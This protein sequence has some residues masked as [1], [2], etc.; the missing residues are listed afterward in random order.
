MH[1]VDGSSQQP[2]YEFDAVRLELE[3]FSPSLSEK[4]YIVAFNK[5]DLPDACEKWDSFKEYLQARGIEPFC[6]SAMHRQGTRDVV[7]AAS[8]LLQK[9]M[10]KKPVEGYSPLFFFSF[11]SVGKGRLCALVFLFVYNFRKIFP[12]HLGSQDYLRT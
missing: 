9:E 8:A 7:S 10:A 12:H 11:C 4:P 2:D 3:L 6:I 1:V 5:M